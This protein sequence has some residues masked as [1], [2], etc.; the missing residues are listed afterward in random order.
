L[1][2][3]NQ[4]ANIVEGAN[5]LESIKMRPSTPVYTE[6]FK[7]DDDA[8]DENY[9]KKIADQAEKD[10]KR[11]ATILL[12][13]L[14]RGRAIQN[15]MFEGKE[16]RLD[17][18]SE[19]RATEEYKNSSDMAEEK[20]LIEVYQE[21][22]LDGVSEAIQSDIISKTMDNLSKELVRLKQERRIAGMVRLAEDVRRKREAE[23]SGRRQA[24]QILR[25]R[26]D[27]LYQELMSV[28]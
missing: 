16:K 7:R 28:H 12:Q 2:Q 5:L 3:Q 11:R 18:I 22:V 4:Q 25:E 24:E 1:K 27:V 6:G 23:E 15:F 13:R 8:K 26:E 10:K 14:I 21:R 19:L 20:N 17:L 9:G